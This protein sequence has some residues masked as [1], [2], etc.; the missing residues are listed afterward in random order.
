[1]YIKRALVTEIVEKLKKTN[2]G[3]IIFWPTA[4]WKNDTG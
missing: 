2:K 3:I 1:M 4:S